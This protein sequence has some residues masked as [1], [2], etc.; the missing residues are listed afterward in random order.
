[1]YLC[2]WAKMVTLPH[3]H[4]YLFRQKKPGEGQPKEFI[5]K[6]KMFKSHVA[7]RKPSVILINALVLPKAAW[8][9]HLAFYGN[10]FNHVLMI[11]V[12]LIQTHSNFCFDRFFK[13]PLAG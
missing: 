11:E 9:K 2:L 6:K 7:K 8:I 5:L 3:V 4:N 1:M 13:V 12:K 10:N